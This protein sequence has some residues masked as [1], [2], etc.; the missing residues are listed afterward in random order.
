MEANLWLLTVSGL[1]LATGAALLLILGI[2]AL[3]GIGG[4]GRTVGRWLAITGI[5]VGPVV[6]FDPQA[7]WVGVV[8]GAL[9]AWGADFVLSMAVRR[10]DIPA[11]ALG[12]CLVAGVTAL[13]LFV[14]YVVLRVIGRIYAFIA[15]L[16]LAM[17]SS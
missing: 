3:I 17:S 12:A 11:P 16:G 7:W 1:V 6:W 14:L 10:P 8:G 13:V 5:I 4:Y 9:L 15:Q 2:G